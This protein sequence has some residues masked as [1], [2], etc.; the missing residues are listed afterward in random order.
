MKALSLMWWKAWAFCLKTD[1]K[2]EKKAIFEKF[3]SKTCAAVGFKPQSRYSDPAAL[4]YGCS[5]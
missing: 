4:Y 3:T 2:G 5:N 1:F